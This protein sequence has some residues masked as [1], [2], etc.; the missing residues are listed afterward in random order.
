MKRA[1]AGSGCECRTQVPRGP[2]GLWLGTMPC[3][4]GSRAWTAGEMPSVTEGT[5]TSSSSISLTHQSVLTGYTNQQLQCKLGPRTGCFTNSHTKS[6]ERAESRG[7]FVFFIAQLSIGEDKG[8]RK[9]KCAKKS[10]SSIL[11]HYTSH[12]SSSACMKHMGQIFQGK[13]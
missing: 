4:S 7:T 3:S 9:K 8:Y 6:D 1:S 5:A 11:F 10:H 13:L 12:A 2:A